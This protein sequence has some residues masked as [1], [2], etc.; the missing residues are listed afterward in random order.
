MSGGVLI[1]VE[2]AAKSVFSDIF[3]RWPSRALLGSTVVAAVCGGLGH[4]VGASTSG[5]ILNG[6]GIT[7]AP[8]RRDRT[9]SRPL[10]QPAGDGS[11]IAEPTPLVAR[12]PAA[13]VQVA[14]RGWRAC[15]GPPARRRWIAEE[16][17]QSAV[18]AAGPS[19]FPRLPRAPTAVMP[20]RLL[21]LRA[22]W[23]RCLQ[24]SA[25]VIRSRSRPTAGVS[26]STPSTTATLVT[27][28]S[29]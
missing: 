6:L 27:S 24:V 20:L 21:C 1:L 9:I 25:V 5:R 4:P 19:T 15:C 13:Q 22:C 29:S 11:A 18:S 28:S 14:H 2:D 16:D 8:V 23:F 7:P 12:V 10:G 26:V 3:P 17:E